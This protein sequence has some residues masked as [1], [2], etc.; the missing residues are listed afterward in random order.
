[1]ISIRSCYHPIDAA[2]LWCDLT[3]HED[4]ILRV[5]LSHPGSLLKH[6]PQ[7]PF[8]HIYAECIYVH[9]IRGAR[10]VE[11]ILPV[12]LGQPEAARVP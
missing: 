6:F 1:M 4:E 5:D 7:W 11:I 10:M 12:R 8:L 3:D 2:I 9:I